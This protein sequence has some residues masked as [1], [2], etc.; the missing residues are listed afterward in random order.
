MPVDYRTIVRDLFQYVKDLGDEIVFI[1]PQCDD[2]KGHR[3][4]NTRNG[5]TNCWRC[6]NEPGHA[7]SFIWWCRSL[8]Y[9]VDDVA[10]PPELGE[11]EKLLDFIDAGDAIIPS[12]VNVRLPKGFRALKQDPQSG[13]CRLIERMAVKKRLTLD[14]MM[15][16]G[17]GFTT[18]SPVWEPFAI[19]P[20]FEYGRL[21]YYQGR[22]YVDV[23]GQTTK[24]FPNRQECP[25]GMQNWIYNIDAIRTRR[26]KLV[27]AVEAIL[28]VLSLEKL[29]QEFVTVSVFKHAVSHIQLSKLAAFKHIEEVCVLYDSD[30]T[31]N[32]WIEAGRKLSNRLRVSIAQMPRVNGKKTDPNDNAQLA[33]EV[34]RNRKPYTPSSE[35]LAQ[36]EGLNSLT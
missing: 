5:L 14:D 16:A 23:E 25:Y 28:N 33:L 34:I 12:V 29:T 32:A 7:G 3:S 8:G 26:P 35:L 31:V 11:I 2:T 22:T 9:N 30:S 6:G 1:C 13:Y 19:F 10:P 20:V 27:V 18:E 24:R 17:V 15:K 36:F 21:V 4:V